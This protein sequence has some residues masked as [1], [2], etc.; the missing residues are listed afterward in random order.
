MTQ[1]HSADPKILLDTCRRARGGGA[2]GRWHVGRAA[3]VPSKIRQS[4]YMLPYPATQ[5]YTT[6]APVRANTHTHM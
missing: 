2:K 1:L 5:A 6:L 4:S 3:L